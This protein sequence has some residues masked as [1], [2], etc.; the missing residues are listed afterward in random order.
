MA[1]ATANFA[2]E[3]DRELLEGW[4]NL[5]GDEFE[6]WATNVCGWEVD[7]KKV[8]IPLNSQN[9]AKPVVSRENVKFD[10]KLSCMPGLKI[11]NWGLEFSRVVK[12]AYEQ[13][14]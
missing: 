3:V 10:R 9:E 2:R 8:V 11:A 5:S 4:V 14:V 12:R 13:P 6:G 1:T 7:A